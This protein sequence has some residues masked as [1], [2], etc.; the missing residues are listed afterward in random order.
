M[1]GMFV[2]NDRMPLRQAIDEILFLDEY[3]EQ[4]EWEQLVVYLPL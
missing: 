3:S 4:D 2:V 1:P